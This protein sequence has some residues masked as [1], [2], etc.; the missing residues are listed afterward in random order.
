MDIHRS[1]DDPNEK[2]VPPELA[3]IAELLL[4]QDL[5]SHERRY[6]TDED[7]PHIVR[8]TE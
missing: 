1:P 2:P 7:E 4:P 5:I 3:T 8:G 6:E